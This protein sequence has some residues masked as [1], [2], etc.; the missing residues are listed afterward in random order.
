LQDEDAFAKAQN[1]LAVKFSTDEMSESGVNILQIPTTGRL[2]NYEIYLFAYYFKVSNWTRFCE[3]DLPHAIE[4]LI[5]QLNSSSSLITLPVELLL[6]ENEFS[7]PKKTPNVLKYFKGKKKDS[8]KSRDCIDL[9]IKPCQSVDLLWLKCG[10]GEDD[11]AKETPPAKSA[12][13]ETCNETN[14]VTSKA[15]VVWPFVSGLTLTV[16]DLL[17]LSCFLELF[18]TVKF[19]FF[20]KNSHSTP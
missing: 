13:K 11:S 8:L 18:S 4:E 6:L 7:V 12:K 15:D 16:A 3:K 14:N 20:L 10:F 5:S 17:V 2:K 1:F 9:E 19:N